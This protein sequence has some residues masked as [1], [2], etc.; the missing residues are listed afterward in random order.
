[1]SLA[2]NSF[3]SFLAGT[4][5]VISAIVS[6][7]FYINEIGAERYGA[8]VI[9]WTLLGYFGQADFGIGRAVTQRISSNIG[10]SRSV[11]A[12]TVWSGIVSMIILGVIGGAL[13]YVLAGYFFGD[14]MKVEPVLRAELM[15]S[16]WALALCNPVVTLTGVL[17]G[18]LIGVE[19]F[20]F[21]SISF[22]AGNLGLQ[23][24]PL[25][26]AMTITHDLQWLVAASLLGRGLGLVMMAAAVW[27]VFLTQQPIRPSWT[28]MRRLAN[29][30]A[31]IMVSSLI[32]PLMI[33]SDRF[34]IGAIYGALAVAVYTIPYQVAYRTLILP[35][36]VVGVL[37]PR[38][39][40]LDDAQALQRCR[41]YLV[42]IGQF[43]APFVIGAICL[44]GPLL[45]LWLGS[46]LDPR[47]VSI[48]HAILVGVWFMA[49]ANVPTA[50][51]QAR[52]NPQFTAMLSIAELP[53]YMAALFLLGRYYGLVG[54]AWAFTLRSAVDACILAWRAGVADRWLFQHVMPTALL[55][56]GAVIAGEMT[57]GWISAIIAAS[58][59]VGACSLHLLYTLSNMD[60]DLRRHFERLPVVGKILMH[61]AFLSAVRRSAGQS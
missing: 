1:M 2:R 46:H 25:V 22:L 48:A 56:I 34:L 55:V 37:F 12:S 61:R 27:R 40:A 47:S 19:K 60:A 30:G 17:S 33:Y 26:A 3:Y 29:F 58:V 21:T 24:L 54:I 50:L 39:A 36:A 13:V 28:E 49:V 23:I 53:F 45:E 14:V 52:G 35:Q 11:L 59:L 10:A 31:W 6:V 18:A 16:L 41:E 43:F 44:A 51:I 8:L 20:K 4:L 15:A 5:P 32:G 57:T 9:A 7:P 42:F 38:F